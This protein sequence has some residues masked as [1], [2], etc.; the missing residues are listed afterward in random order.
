MRPVHEYFDLN[1]L[2]T[3]VT[4]VNEKSISEAAK[5]L[6]VTQPAVSAAL[7]RLEMH[8]DTSL[9][10]RTSR[11]FHVTEAG[12]KV[13]E[14]AIRILSQ[15]SRL[16]INIGDD[17]DKIE[18]SLKIGIVS[19][20]RIN[21]FDKSLENIHTAHPNITCELIELLSQDIIRSVAFESLS[22]G[23]TTLPLKSQSIK[24]FL[25]GTQRYKL[26]CGRTHPLYKRNDIALSDLKNCEWVS[27]TNAQLSGSLFEIEKFRIKHSLHGKNAAVTQS[28]NEARRLIKCGWGIGCLPESFARDEEI[29]LNLRALPPAEGVSN[30]DLY[31]IWN[32][33]TVLTGAE[34][35]AID[36]IKE[37]AFFH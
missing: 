7:K 29:K 33:Q 11:H 6:Y 5:K 18:G 35:A 37:H 16:C 22:L 1:L 8:L 9:I 21:I 25:L 27:Y 19:G 10:E 17:K 4:I 36:I 12:L 20:V 34:Q 2:R 3:F 24:S 32:S 23:I 31:V 14:E 28:L 30:I 13:Y 15:V 26:Y